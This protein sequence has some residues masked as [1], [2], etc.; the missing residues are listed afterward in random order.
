MNNMNYSNHEELMICERLRSMKLSGMADAL[1]NQLNDPNADLIPFMKR[2]IDIVD[3]EW[4]MRYDK[5]FNRYLKQAHLRYPDADLD[6]S[7]YEPAR[8][9]DTAVIEKLATCHWIDEGKNLLITGKTSSGK[10]HLCNALCIS[11]IRQMKTV[12]YFRANTLIL[13]MEQARLKSTYLDYIRNISRIDLLAIDD[14]G[15]MKLEVDGCRDLFEV[16]DARSER[17]STIIIS[18]FPI[19]AW[20]DLFKDQTFADA[21]LARLTDKK[22]SYRVEMNGISM[23]DI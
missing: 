18:Q 5:K 1:G 11:A 12:R 14:F 2:F 9:L 3:T 20:F 8:M 19:K 16:I 23:R 13:E 17:K 22:H 21:I 10:T 6:E 4:Q 7:I 15:L